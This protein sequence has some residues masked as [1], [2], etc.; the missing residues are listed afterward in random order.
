MR[1]VLTIA[2]IVLLA[3]LIVI[4]LGGWLYLRTSLPNTSGTVT[5]AGLDGRVEIVRDAD[6]VPHVFATTSDDAYFALGYVHAQDRLWQMEFHRRIGAGRL[7][8]M[9][10]DATLGTDKFMRTLGVYRMAQSAYEALDPNTTAIVDAYAAGVNAWLAEGHTLPV[11]FTILGVTPE[12]WQP[13]D[14]LAWAKLMAYDLGGNF[15]TELL[16]VRLLQTLGPERTAQLMPDYPQSG[17]TILAAQELAPA[18]ADS[19]L[20]LDSFLQLNLQLGGID[21]G[22]NNWVVAGS[23]TDTGLPL[24]ANDPHLGSRIPSIWYLVELSGGP[25]HVTGA[26]FPGL[27]GVATGHNDSIAWG[28]TNLGPDVQDLYMERV[29]PANLNQYEVDG[30]WVDMV[31]VEE[32][33]TVKGEDEPVRWAARSTR[34]GP[35]L[36]DVSGGTTSPVA[37]RWPALDATDT[38]I[39]AFANAGTATNWEEFTASLRDY[40]AP[41]QNFVYADKEGNIGYY[42]PGRIP[43]RAEGHDGMTP[44]PGWDSQYE[45]QGWI[46]FEEMPHAYNPAVGYI[47]TANNKAIPADYP[48]FVSNEWAPP[49]RAQRITEMLLEMSSNGQTL[50]MADMAAIQ[51][52]QTSLQAKELLPLMLATQAKDIRQAQA[53]GIL[54][55]WDGVSAVDSTAAAIYMAWYMQL[56][57]AIFQDDLSRDLYEEMSNRAHPT[58]LADIMAQADSPWC[59]NVRSFPAENCAAI[60]QEALDTALDDLETRLGD[61]M[62]KWQW[63]DIHFTYYPHNPFTEVSPLNRIFD[64]KIAN[65]G[66]TYTVNVAPVRFEPRYEQRWVPSYRHLVD[67]SDLN[68]S[69]FM[70]TTGQSGNLLSPHYDDLIE[71]HQA[72]EYLPMTWGRENVSGDVLVLQPK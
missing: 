49:Y 41:S 18:T 58:F 24:L 36:S 32:L 20:E 57:P 66:D 52:D 37:L 45:W 47:V 38:T 21:V 6:G 61:D 35:L 56:G 70:H 23:R 63:G 12:P 26:T 54:Q 28:V 68:A 55:A 10:G 44:V 9:L 31:I 8:E 19:L 43:V 40:V 14:S 5:V 3:L 51:A 50:S 69:Q 15:D 48:Y 39:T 46:P 4:P 30:A 71:R 29:N 22:S 65:G 62:T 33:I 53:L 42:A 7:S 17:V 25:L 64:R 72:V 67:L 13:A 11:E 1:R 60:A 34:H 27:P 59:D 16:R 2:L